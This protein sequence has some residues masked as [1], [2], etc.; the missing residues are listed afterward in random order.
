MS[1]VVHNFVKLYGLDGDEIFAEFDDID[2]LPNMSKVIGNEERIHPPNLTSD[3]ANLMRARR[4]EMTQ[5]T[6]QRTYGD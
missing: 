2:R 1:C 4:D 3:K 5:Q 6:W